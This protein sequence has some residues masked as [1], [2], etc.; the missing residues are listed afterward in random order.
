MLEARIRGDRRAIDRETAHQQKA[1]SEGKLNPH[2][3]PVV[4][5]PQ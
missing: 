4:G 2:R 5:Q 3:P 1:I